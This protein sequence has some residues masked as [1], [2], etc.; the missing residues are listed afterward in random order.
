MKKLILKV[1]GSLLYSD[2]LAFNTDI[3][4][5]IGHW[6]EKQREFDLIVF[7]I[8]G[9]KISRFVVNQ[10][11]ENIKEEEFKHR[12]G[13][14]MT[15]VNSAI[16]HGMIGG[17]DCK[18]FDSLKKLFKSVRGKKLKG[19]VIGGASVGGSTDMVAANIAFQLGADTVHKISNISNIFC[20]DPKTNLDAQPIEKL[21]WQEYTKLFEAVFE[22]GHQPGMNIPVDFRCASFCEEHGISFRVCGGE[23]LKSMEIGEVLKTGTIVK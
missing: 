12:I 4:K 7:V 17:H 22:H 19:A 2:E 13:M 10:V 16:F 6:Y 23:N 14:K 9:G 15:Q 21:S 8:G 5:K 18:Y 1:G 3:V 20:S 11:K